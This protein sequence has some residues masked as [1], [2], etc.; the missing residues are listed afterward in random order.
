MADHIRSHCDA[1]DG[2][3]KRPGSEA[4]HHEDRSPSTETHLH[5]SGTTH[6]EGGQTSPQTSHARHDDDNDDDGHYSTTASLH[7]QQHHADDSAPNALRSIP[8]AAGPDA[9]PA[10]PVEPSTSFTEV[11]DH[12]YDVFSPRRKLAIVMLMSF[13]AFL[14][15]VSSTTVLS[16]TP[17]VAAEFGTS[18]SVVDVSNALYLLAMGVSPIVWGP[19]SEVWGRKVVSFL[20]LVWSMF[21]FGPAWTPGKACGKVIFFG[22]HCSRIASSGRAFCGTV[23]GGG[24]EQRSQG[25]VFVEL[26][27][28][29]K[30][31]VAA[32]W[33]F[34]Q[35]GTWYLR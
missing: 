25:W 12:V 31:P 20:F 27:P 3:R 34:W 17:E 22:R 16:A 11:P 32:M 6:A 9:P 2:S 18:G 26:F 21:C 10:A 4:K 24:R 23:T 19:F 1:L 5:D 33:H 13:C 15:P 8:T 28:L 30:C 14:A 29:G 35:T 7:H